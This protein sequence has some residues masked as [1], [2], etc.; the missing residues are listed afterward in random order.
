MAGRSRMRAALRGR[1]PG[2]AHE[3]SCWAEGHH[4]V[5]GLDEVG[6]GA[7]AGPLT[8][9]A[10]VPSR[11]R[12]IMGVRDSKM[13]TEP[14]REA[15][16]DR[17]KGWAEAWS[18]GHATNDECDELGMSDAQRLAAR[19]ALDGLGV[20]PDAVLLDGRWDFVGGG[21]ARTIVG[22]DAACLSIA[23]ASVVA[24][25]T[26]D[27]LL[28]AA[29]NRFSGYGFAEGKGYPNPAHRAALLERGATVYHRRSWSF[30]EGLPDIGAPR[31]IGPRHG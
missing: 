28:R 12:R 25:V 6:R 17:I 16:V 3:R 10:V 1:A 4:I 19:R 26:R 14:E 24:K 11:E 15:L 31:R 9:A 2:L 18:V 5:A 27:R 30:M 20:T 13:L 21:I 22:G 23:A 7:W 8:V 29:D